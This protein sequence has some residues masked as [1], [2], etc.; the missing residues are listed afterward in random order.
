MQ[1]SKKKKFCLKGG[2]AENVIIQHIHIM[3]RN[4]VRGNVKYIFLNDKE[5]HSNREIMKITSLITSLKHFVYYITAMVGAICLDQFAFHRSVLA[6]RIYKKFCD[7]KHD[8]FTQ[9]K[10]ESLQSYCARVHL[11]PEQEHFTHMH[12]DQSF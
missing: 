5:N 3:F 1:R 4:T 6:A 7:F 2:C 8:M 11:E 9:F 12:S 10:V